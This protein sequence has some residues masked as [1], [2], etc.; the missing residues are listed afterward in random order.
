MLCKKSTLR[1]K[2]SG[3]TLDTPL[4]IPS[5]SSRVFPNST[6]TRIKSDLRKTFETASEFLTDVLLISAYDIH[7][8]YL[9]RPTAFPHT[10]ELIFVDSGGYEISESSDYSTV[11]DRRF[12]PKPWTIDNLK[13][14]FENWPDEV[15][16]VFVS[17]DHPD[18][19]K[20]LATQASEARQLFRNHRQHLTLLL[21][22]PETR[23]QTTLKKTINAAV[24]D[25]GDLGG[26]DIIGVAEKELGRTMMERMCEVAR[27]RIA[28][29]NA[30]VGAPL[31]VFG[32]LDPLSVCLYYISGAEIFDGLT[33]IRYAYDEGVCVYKHNF[34]AKR[35]GLNVSDDGVQSRCLS[36]NVYTLADL[37]ER[38]QVFESTGDFD[39]LRPHDELVKDASESLQARF[40]WRF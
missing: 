3:I 30:G 14:V 26:F 11:S 17:F 22:K 2:D 4:L 18:E 32:A 5:F 8:G 1:H 36:D 13:S 19:R 31:H 10:T 6:I 20:P 15:P 37:R 12:R 34:A 25:A 21:L 35:Y 9:P 28:M 23:E 40:K 16:A 24:G 33:W 7:Y 29:D 39:K 38:M 27:L